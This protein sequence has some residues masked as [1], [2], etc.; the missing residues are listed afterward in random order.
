MIR[1][2]ELFWRLVEPEHSR[3]RA[4]CRKLTGNRDDGDDLY[5]DALIR[6]L[7]SF[8][9]LKDEL[10]FKSWLYRIIVNIFKNRVRKPWYGRIVSLIS[11]DNQS[12]PSDN[13]SG[14]YTARRQLDSALKTLSVAD[15]ALILLF[16]I[17]GWS[18]RELAKTWESS[19]G[20]IKVRLSRA[21]A[22]MR[23]HL[24]RSLSAKDSVRNRKP[25]M[26]EDSICV[27]PK[28]GAD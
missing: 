20:A 13:P 17:E 16:E 6:A 24:V 14:C 19:E 25:S 12:L 1:N 26:N 7:E 23:N 27:V 9:N 10:A 15:R 11:S 18:I 28:P 4:F 21:R 22:K 5:Q 2:R 8:G 3:I